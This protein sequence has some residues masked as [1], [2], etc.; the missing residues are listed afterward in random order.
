M[1]QTMKKKGFGEKWLAWMKMIFS[2][3]TSSILLNGTPSK[4]LHYKRGVRQ[5]DPLSPLL[6]VLAA[7]LLQSVINKA[8]DQGLLKLPVPL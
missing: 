3:G 4:V 7:D 5:G 1:Q 8:K 2:S 6:F